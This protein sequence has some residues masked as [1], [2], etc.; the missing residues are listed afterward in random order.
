MSNFGWQVCILKSVN[1]LVIN[2]GVEI[3]IIIRK[4]LNL[5]VK[6]LRNLY[7]FFFSKHCL[8]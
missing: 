4:K 5:T 2:L 1:V 7:S 8:I 6:K 3:K